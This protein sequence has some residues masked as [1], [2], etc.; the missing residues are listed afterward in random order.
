MAAL[1]PAVLQVVAEALHGTA[2]WMG[3]RSGKLPAPPAAYRAS[4][5]PQ[6]ALD[7]VLRNP[8]PHQLH[9]LLHNVS[10]AGCDWPGAEVRRAGGRWGRLGLGA[11][12]TGV[13]SAQ[14][15]YRLPPWALDAGRHGSSQAL[16][17][18]LGSGCATS[19]SGRRLGWPRARFPALL[20]HGRWPAADDLGAGMGAQPLPYTFNAAIGEEIGDLAALQ[21]TENGAATSSL[22]PA[23]SS[24]P[25]MSGLGGGEL[26][27]SLRRK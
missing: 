23:Q 26:G 24:M 1:L 25:R 11:S 2:A 10:D 18:A 6:G 4:A 14:A 13:F 17:R 3:T 15:E 27:S 19:V 8:L 21:I 20:P 5:N 22:A 7:R 12:K 9:H 16:V